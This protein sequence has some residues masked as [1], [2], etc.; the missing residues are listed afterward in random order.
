MAHFIKK[1]CQKA[2][3]AMKTINT[4]TMTAKTFPITD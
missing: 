4:T 1:E 2:S 3:F